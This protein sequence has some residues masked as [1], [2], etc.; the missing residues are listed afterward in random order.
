MH[1]QTL[2]RKCREATNAAEI[3]GGRF[4]VFLASVSQ[5][6]FVHGEV[7]VTEVTLEWLLICVHFAD[8]ILEEEILAERFSTDRALVLLDAGRVHMR[9]FHVVLQIVSIVLFAT[10]IAC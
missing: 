3:T 5:H 2:L 8:V 10:Q 6:V 7:G 4:R 1:L 9:R